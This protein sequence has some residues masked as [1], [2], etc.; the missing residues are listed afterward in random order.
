LFFITMPVPHSL[1][2]EP[3]ICIRLAN[4]VR[5]AGDHTPGD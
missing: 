3:D 4:Y 5:M 2:I 1:Y